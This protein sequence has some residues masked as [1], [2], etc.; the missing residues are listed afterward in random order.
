MYYN[1]TPA[2]QQ[3]FPSLGG[4]GGGG[5]SGSFY[6]LYISG[7]QTSDVLLSR[8]QALI[9]RILG[10]RLMFYERLCFVSLNKQVHALLWS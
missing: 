7:R 1:E 5:A 3:F 8:T 10:T 4:G 9:V 2:H 6:T